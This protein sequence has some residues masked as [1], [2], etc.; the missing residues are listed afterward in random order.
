MKRA[1]IQLALLLP[2]ILNAA[3]SGR[4]FMGWS[5][6]KNFT[7]CTNSSGEVELLSPTTPC[8]AADEF[9]PS[10]NADLATDGWLR[11]ELRTFRGKVPTKFYDLGHW[12]SDAPVH[13]RESVK[14]QKDDDGDVDTDTLQLT[15]PADSFQFKITLGPS[16]NTAKL[17]LLAVSAMDTKAAPKPRSP[18]SSV[19]GKAPL[20]VPQRSQCVWP[21]GVNKWCSPTTTSMLLAFWSVKLNRP[22]WNFEVPEVAHAIY[23]STWNGTGNWA[24]NMAFAGA[25]PGV[26]AMV[27]RF[28]D[29]RELEEW[30]ASGHPVGVSLCS[31]RL[32]GVEN[33]PSGHL[34]VCVGF[35]ADGSVILNNPGTLHDTQKT[36]PRDVFIHSWAYSKQ[37]VYLVYPEGE[38]LPTDKLGHW[39]ISRLK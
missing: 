29:V 15:A 9:I 22:E 2:L 26:C 18:L 17:K 23:D 20:P 38:K 35:T 5:D 25:Q 11:I 31:N 6:L 14:G 36:Y 34:V 10:W 1:A 33:P 19:W 27:S 37:T 39:T 24:F 32:R 13:P 21:E 16:T 3:P 30:I 28:D 4:Q 12:S 7:R 8:R